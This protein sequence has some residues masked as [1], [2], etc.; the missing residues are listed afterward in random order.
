MKT[1]VRPTRHPPLETDFD[2]VLELIDAARTRTIAA[3]NTALI[4][5]YWQIGEH[6]SQ[7]IAASGWGAGNGHGARRVHPPPAAE[8]AGVFGSKP[9]ADAA[10][11]RNLP[12]LAKTL[13]N[14]ERIAVD[15]QPTD[16]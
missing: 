15:A 4:D 13:S 2:R 7:R 12:L 10:V 5:L 9:V 3:A 8:R 1:A 14:A 11:L 6:I 16:S